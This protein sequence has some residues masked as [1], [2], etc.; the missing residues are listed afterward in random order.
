[1]TK[2]SNMGKSY[3]I[4]ALIFSAT[5]TLSFSRDVILHGNAPSYAGCEILFNRYTDWITNGEEE[6]G[7]CRVD[8]TGNFSVSMDLEQITFVFSHLGI[9]KAF[10]YAEPGKTYEIILPEREDKSQEDELN[11][12][13]TESRIQL[14]TADVSPDDINFMIRMFNDAY[15]PYYNKHIISFINNDDFSELN[16]DIERLEKPFTGSVNSFFNR[17]RDYRYGLLRHLAY[18]QKSRSIS[19]EYFRK[20]PVLFNNPAY[21]ELFTQVYDKYFV[22]FGMT[23]KGSRIYS[24]INTLKSYDDLKKT[25]LKDNVFYNDTIVELVILLNIYNEFYSDNFSRAGL[26]TVLDTLISRTGVEQNRKIGETIRAKITRLLSGYNPPTFE[27]FDADSNLVRLDDLKGKYVYLNFCTS[28]SYTCLGEF[29]LLKG[30]YER[31]KEKLEIVTIDVEAHRTSF[32]DFQKNKNWN[33]K[34]LYYANQPHILKDYD[35]RAYPTYF[36]IGPD[37]K[38]I[39]SPSPS[40][41]ENFESLLVKAMKARGDL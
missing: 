35:I 17:Y 29:E 25:L 37:G 3:F 2:K 19:E 5:F 40:P 24:D 20:R 41:A 6:I 8:T 18:Q 34:F 28:L 16:A 14:G 1:M 4:L 30:L 15:N 31:Y 27:L 39:Y 36:L 13:F 32:A 9:Y 10:L 12:Y 21:M 7:R 38:L 22:F 33:W 23:D 11:P 26:L